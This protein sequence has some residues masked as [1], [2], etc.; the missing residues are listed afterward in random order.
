MRLKS[1]ARRRPSASMLVAIVAL[2]M[3]LGG[4]GYAATV[5]PANSVGTAQI[6]NDAVNYKKIL[7]RSVGVVRLATDGVTTSKI[8]DDNVTFDKIHPNAVGR[9]RANLDQLQARL[10]ATCPT[11]SAIGSVAKTGAVTC[12]PALPAHTVSPAPAAPVT[13]A[14]GTTPTTVTTVALPAGASYMAFSNPALTV[15]GAGSGTQVAQHI[16]L[17]CTLTVGTTTQSRSVTVDV[18]ANSGADFTTEIPLQQSGAAGPSTT[19]CTATP[20]TGT[21]PAV[22]ATGVIDA[23][24]TAG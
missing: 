15:T 22:K 9:V 16:T 12:N 5:L 14:P 17:T 24:Q 18:P 2:V 6:R 20:D 8:R 11:G 4:V 10:K 19:A 23:L 7:P 3:S 13:V 1:L 21:L